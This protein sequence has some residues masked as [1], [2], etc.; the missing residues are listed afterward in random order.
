MLGFAVFGAGR[1]GAL[2]AA[3]VATHPAAKLVSVYDVR[4]PAA[5]ALSGRLGA[6]AAP[7]VEAALAD[8]AVGAALIASSTDTHVDLITAAARAGKAVFCEKPIDL[9]IGRVERCRKEIAGTGV[10]VQIGFNRRY[11]ASHRALRDAVRAGE[12]GEPE[13]VIISSRDPEP[14][15]ADFLK[16]SGGLFRDMMIHDFDMARFVL[17]E[18]PVEVFAAGS[19]KVDPAIGAI[20]DVDTAMVTMKTASGVL[21]HINNSRRAVYGY[22][23]RIEAFGSM[24]MLLSDNRRATTLER[25]TERAT[26]A[27][28]PLLRFFIERYAEA[29]A[30]ELDDFIAAVE[31][32][33][34]P[35]VG[36][37]DGRRALI[38]ADAAFESN[39]IGRPVKVRYD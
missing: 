19:V 24:G 21:V 9:D 11:D 14:A 29:Y 10:P 17:G 16:T 31:K 38:L 15:S 28:E 36:F 8:R 5:E 25:H 7:S 30:R 6:K 34:P 32:G 4:R 3:N 1:I 18:E 20:G 22:D 27:K 33:A 35:A 12:I 2:H 23:Q 37:E 39:R 13:L 26:A